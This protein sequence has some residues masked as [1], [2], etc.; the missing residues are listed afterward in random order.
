MLAN[1]EYLKLGLEDTDKVEGF[2]KK[3]YLISF[4]ANNGKKT[5]SLHDIDQDKIYSNYHT[6][7]EYMA[8]M[9]FWVV[10]HCC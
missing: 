8:K 1:E 2:L 6:M 9:S 3:F 10:C 5:F 4:E 7:M